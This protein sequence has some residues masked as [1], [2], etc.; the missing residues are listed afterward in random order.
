MGIPVVPVRCRTPF[1]FGTHQFEPGRVYLLHFPVARLFASNNWVEREDV[2]YAGEIIDLS[3]PEF[4]MT[5]FDIVSSAQVGKSA[6]GLA[7]LVAHPPGA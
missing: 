5:A 7:T 4:L 3:T 1:L 2:R 6:F